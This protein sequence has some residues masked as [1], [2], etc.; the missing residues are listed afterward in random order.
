MRIANTLLA[1]LK[2]GAGL[3][4]GIVRRLS[5]S[6]TNIA[7]ASLI[8]GG[9]LSAYFV[10]GIGLILVGSAAMAIVGAFRSEIPGALLATPMAVWL[11]LVVTGRTLALDGRSLFVTFGGF[12]L[13]SDLLCGFLL[14]ALGR[15]KVAGLLRF[16]P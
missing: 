1:D 2:V 4:I 11:V 12:V 13:C 9:I 6:V 16:V 8:I 3:T 10:E 5:Y 15:F 7:I 14:Y